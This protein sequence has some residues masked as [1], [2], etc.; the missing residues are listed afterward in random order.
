MNDP[1]LYFNRP[2]EVADVDVEGDVGI[3]AKA[4]L[5]TREAVS[6]LFNIGLGHDRNFF[7]RDGTCCL[8]KKKIL[9][10]HHNANNARH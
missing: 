8:V 9:L 10:L 1:Y 2:G 6:V 4:E 7:S 5:L 3:T